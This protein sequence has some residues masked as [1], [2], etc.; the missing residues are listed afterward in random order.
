M[1]KLLLFLTV[2]VFTNAKA[3]DFLGLQSSNY[4]GVIGAYSNPAI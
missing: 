2:L 3:Q 4:A 1:K